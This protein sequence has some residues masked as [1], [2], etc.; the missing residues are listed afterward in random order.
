MSV[1]PGEAWKY[2]VTSSGYRGSK[3]E[4]LVGAKVNENLSEPAD[5]FITNSIIGGIAESVLDAEG[6]TK[7]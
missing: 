6:K 2:E 5:M 1:R 7:T 4:L 3:G